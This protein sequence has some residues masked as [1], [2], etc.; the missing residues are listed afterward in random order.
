[1]LGGALLIT[2]TLLGLFAPLDNVL[3]DPRFSL[4]QRVATG[5][6]VFVDIDAASLE[7][8]GRW[9]WPRSVHARL[10]DELM[11]LGADKVV[12]DIDF[13]LPSDEA[14]DAE[15]ER[16]LADAGGY[17]LLAAFQQQQVGQ[18]VPAVNM[19]IGR[20]AQ[21][22]DPVAVNVT[23]DRDGIVRSYPLGMWLDG[24][25]VPSVASVLAGASPTA[26]GRFG[27]DYAIDPHTVPRIAARDL[28]A[29]AVPA[30]AVEG[31]NVV[32]GAS[33]VELRDFFVVPRHGILPGALLQIVASETLQQG[34]PLLGLG[35]W[36]EIGALVLL[37][38]I[39]A[40]LRSGQP[41]WAIVLAALSLGLGT[42]AIATVLQL[43][44]ALILDTASI[45]LGL[46]ALLLGALVDEVRR[47][48]EQHR[49][50][51]RERD[52]V[53]TILDRVITDNFDGVVIVDEEGT[54]LS[55]SQSAAAL[56]GR[57]LLGNK[58]NDVLPDALQ[59]V[60]RQCFCGE[61]P[62]PI[63][64]LSVDT[65]DGPRQLEYA[66]TRSAVE[67]TMAKRTVVSLTFRD[68]TERRAAEDRLLFLSRHDPVTGALTRSALLDEAQARLARGNE[69]SLVMFDLR[70][71]R[72][73]NDTLGHNQGDVLLRL[74]VTRLRNMGPD[75]V[76]R[77]GA[78]S[79]ALLAP[80]MEPDRLAGYALSIAEW[81]SFPY[82]LDD[83]HRAV[84]AASAG[85]TTSLLSGRDAE[86]LLS[87]ADMA[88]S[89]A[90]EGVGNGVRLFEPGMGDRLHASRNMDSALREA[91]RLQQLTLV[92]QPQIDLA[93]GRVI[94]AEA[95]C[96]WTD[97]V[98]GTVSPVDFIAAAEET[99]LIVE[100]GAWVLE[101]ACREAARWPEELGLAVNVSPLQFELSDVEQA[102]ATALERTGLHP[103]RLDIEIT[104]GVFVRNAAEVTATLETIRAMGVGI[105][106]DDFGTGYSSLGYLGRLPVDKIKI[107]QR[108]VR[109]LPGDPESQAIVTA[110]LSLSRA[111][112]K[113]TVAE[114]IETQAQAELLRRAGCTRGQGYHFGRPM[115]SAALCALAAEKTAAVA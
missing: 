2:A 25:W 51:A 14:G 53:R 75:A 76:A 83:G 79:F 80:V 92:Y 113:S 46:A 60:L 103:S 12:F 58:A 104:E 32:I 115:S 85:A 20:F 47:R 13:S 89:V 26:Q 86:T 18:V 56:L 45:H 22:A 33:A 81:L 7:S 114:G 28:L 64:E 10:L 87:H 31:R 29:G 17:A 21:H 94:G 15:F 41:L 101:A 97:P 6:T 71:F 9:P 8:V 3:R 44:L 57:T 100:L 67:T 42:E 1:V 62:P 48:G 91:I 107:D 108:F 27:I 106:L 78:D 19:P 111:L 39:G 93:T 77:L 88:L 69:L 34:R 11:A 54:V 63:R 66:A 73:I 35:V 90:K 52:A 102:V 74:A 4:G 98:L 68:I 55:A 61:T 112:G 16:A 43:R 36:P 95:L 49:R 37:I 105:A 82:Q 99:G 23:L 24:T 72:A 5:A 96:R 84:V 110:V 65:P 59:R 50:A 38:G 30:E 70:R 109:E 40:W